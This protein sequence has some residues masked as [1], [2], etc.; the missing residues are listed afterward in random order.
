[1]IAVKEVR[2][3][4]FQQKEDAGDRQRKE[5]ASPVLKDGNTRNKTGNVEIVEIG[6]AAV[7]VG[8]RMMLY[9]VGAAPEVRGGLEEGELA[10][11]VG[12][13]QAQP[14]RRAKHTM[15]TEVTD[16][17]ELPEVAAD[18]EHAKSSDDEVLAA[19]KD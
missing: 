3:A 13:Q 4:P 17:L 7:Q 15:D 1:V 12:Q 10:K 9:E 18:E 14:P 6:V 19:L 5:H 11:D 16:L 2:H 8:M